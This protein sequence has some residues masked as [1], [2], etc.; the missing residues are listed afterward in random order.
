[1]SNETD[2]IAFDWPPGN[3]DPKDPHPEIVLI[4]NVHQWE[5][6]D[7]H[8]INVHGIGADSHMSNCTKGSVAVFAGYGITDRQA[9]WKIDLD[10]TRCRDKTYRYGTPFFVATPFGRFPRT[11]TVTYQSRD[12][13]RRLQVQVYSWLPGGERQGG[14]SFSWH[15]V[16]PIR[17]V[18]DLI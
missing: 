4:S 6:T 18:D 12:D 17:A 15:C 5:Q 14:V 7:A 3:L 2:Q 11:L 16:V 13:G 9:V 1:M 8:V 10:K